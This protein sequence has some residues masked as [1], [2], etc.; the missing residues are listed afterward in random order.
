MYSYSLINHSV[1]LNIISN[2][3][4]LVLSLSGSRM[5]TLKP[6]KTKNTSSMTY[7]AENFN[8]LTTSRHNFNSLGPISMCENSQWPTARNWRGHWATPPQ[9]EEETGPEDRTHAVPSTLS[10]SKYRPFPSSH[11]AQLHTKPNA[12][13][14]EGCARILCPHPEN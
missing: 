1:N 10:S 2:V 9:A 3:Y 7:E 12:S 13:E 5:L 14:K 11:K 8:K 4:P 6:R